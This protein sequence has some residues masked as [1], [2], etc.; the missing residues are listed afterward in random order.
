MFC[1]NCGEKNCDDAAFCKEC[2][3]PIQGAKKEGFEEIPHNIAGEPKPATGGLQVWLWITIVYNSLSGLLAIYQLSF[4]GSFAFY[5]Y[6]SNDY[7]L[8]MFYEIVLVVGAFRLL[9]GFKHGFYIL[10]I[11]AAVVFFANLNVLPVGIAGLVLL[12]IT[13]MFAKGQWQ[14]FR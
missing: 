10:C 8:A 12:G 14:F 7:I 9:K 1:P 3:A 4:G 11:G 6:S 13:W 5:Y 2:G